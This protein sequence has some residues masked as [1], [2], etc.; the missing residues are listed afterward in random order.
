MLTWVRGS[1]ALCCVL[2]AVLCSVVLCAV[3]YV[4]HLRYKRCAMCYVLGDA[5]C[6]LCAVLG[7]CC[8]YDQVHDAVSQLMQVLSDDRRVRVDQVAQTQKR[9]C[10]VL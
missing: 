8:T 9:V 1:C 7:W 2:C 4:M 3:C 5:C 6:V 10:G